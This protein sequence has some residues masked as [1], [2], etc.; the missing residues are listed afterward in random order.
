MK[1]IL[2][3]QRLEISRQTPTPLA[4]AIKSCDNQS[5]SH[6]CS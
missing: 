1:R 5:C 3:L 2:A 4:S 6:N